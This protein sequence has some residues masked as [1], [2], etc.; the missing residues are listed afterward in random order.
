M[1]S[2]LIHSPYVVFA[3]SLTEMFSA[4]IV[5]P[6]DLESCQVAIDADMPHFLFISDLFV[7]DLK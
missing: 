6:G 1:S 3:I 4:S 5:Q 2:L 7:F